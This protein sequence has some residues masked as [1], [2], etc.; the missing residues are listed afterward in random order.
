MFGAWLLCFLSFLVLTH[1]EL[2]CRM[3]KWESDIAP[4]NSTS[5]ILQSILCARHIFQKH[6]LHYA[7]HLSKNIQWLSWPPGLSP[8]SPACQ[9][10][11]QCF[12]CLT[13]FSPLFEYIFLCVIVWSAARLGMGTAVSPQPMAFVGLI[14][15][16]SFQHH[17]LILDIYLYT[18]QFLYLSFI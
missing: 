3:K 7:A 10:F 13:I 8:C 14:C 2:S 15:F 17:V 6:S 12:L 1:R 4:H 18:L 5:F 9:F 11:D 16:L